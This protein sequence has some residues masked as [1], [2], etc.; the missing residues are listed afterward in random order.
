VPVPALRPSLDLCKPTGVTLGAGS[1]VIVALD[2]GGVG[3]ALVNRL[4]KRD[5][6]VL[7]LDAQQPNDASD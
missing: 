5:V 7:A 3:R 6:N 4:E 1:R 2:R